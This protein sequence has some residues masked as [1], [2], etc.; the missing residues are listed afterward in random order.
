MTVTVSRVRAAKPATMLDAADDVRA[1]S[2]AL[3]IVIGVERGQL[4][5]LKA[6]WHG[7]AADAAAAKA[8]QLIDDQEA[9]RS[10]L[11][12]LAK[13]LTEGGSSSARCARRYSNWST[14]Q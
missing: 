10:R 1:T 9:H 8:Q 3:E 13:A 5:N 14:P 6:N 11:D 2:G 4:A 7:A 12:K